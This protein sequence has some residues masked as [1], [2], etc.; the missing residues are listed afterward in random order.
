MTIYNTAFDTFIGRSLLIKPIQEAVQDLEVSRILLDSNTNVFLHLQSWNEDS[1][2]KYVPTVLTPQTTAESAIGVFHHP[3]PVVIPQAG[4]QEDRNYLVG[5]ARSF[6]TMDRTTKN[7][8]VSNTMEFEFL[9]ARLGLGAVWLSQ[10][11]QALRF[12][13][14]ITQTIFAS[15]IAE[16]LTR[17]FALDMGQQMRLQVLAGLFYHCQFTAEEEEWGDAT[18]NRMAVPLSKVAKAPIDETVSLLT[19]AGHITSVE[20]FVNKIRACLDNPRLENL[21][22]GVLSTIMAGTWFGFGGKEIACVAL[23][24][25]PTFMAM[26]YIALNQRGFKNAP[27]ANL[28]ERFKGPKG[29]DEFTRAVKRTVFE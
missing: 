13:S 21:N 28:V 19:Q 27:L 18:I 16:N 22:A 12:L 11:T 15:W 17:R 25:P 9:Q 7:V 3:M 24:H 14:P 23:E 20:D 5:D 29:G 26:V 10:G 6:M 4:K 2:F 1:R 8:Y